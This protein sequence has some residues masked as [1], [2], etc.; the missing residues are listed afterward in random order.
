MGNGNDLDHIRAL[1][2]PPHAVPAPSSNIKV[3][4]RKSVSKV[5]DVFVYVGWFD[6]ESVINLGETTVLAWTVLLTCSC[7]NVSLTT[8]PLG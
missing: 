2:H 3:A 5:H 8:G 4:L 6:D 1:M 7:P